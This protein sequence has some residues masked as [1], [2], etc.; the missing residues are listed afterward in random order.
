MATSKVVPSPTSVTL[1]PSM[2]PSVLAMSVGLTGRPIGHES[3]A[4]TLCFF[5]KA[6]ASFDTRHDHCLSIQMLEENWP[7]GSP[8]VV[9]DCVKTCL[10]G[11]WVC[12]VF[13]C[14]LIMLLACWVVACLV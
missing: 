6:L 4:T 8:G 7:H 3:F 10:V 13:F 12:V 1:A 11:Y 5:V 14:R 2:V 9:M